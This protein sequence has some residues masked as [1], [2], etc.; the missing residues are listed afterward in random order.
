MSKTLREELAKTQSSTKT[1]QTKWAQERVEWI[2]GC[3][4]VQS[5]HRIAHLRTSLLLDAEKR[6]GMEDR[7]YVRKEALGRVGR[8]FKILLFQIREDELEEQVR[9]LQEEVDA[10]RDEAG[11]EKARL[12][13][14]H[15]EVVRVWRDKC[16]ALIERVKE[17]ESELEVVQNGQSDVEVWVFYLIC[18]RRANGI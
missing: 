16:I 6:A 2:K 1:L 14:K 3:D 5:A 18:V 17:R 15:K 8:D 9:E 11:I 13:A 10:V 12:V 7:D 4:A